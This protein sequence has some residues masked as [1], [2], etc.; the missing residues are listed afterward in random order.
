MR[1]RHDQAARLREADRADRRAKV[2]VTRGAVRECEGMEAPRNDV[3]VPKG[4][5]RGIV[6]RAFAQFAADG[7]D[8]IKR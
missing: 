8:R 4:V 1:Q 2:E 5:A 3:D 6:R 7:V